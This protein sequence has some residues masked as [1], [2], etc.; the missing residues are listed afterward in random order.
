MSTGK[1]R[2]GDRQKDGGPETKKDR[3]YKRHRKKKMMQKQTNR[4][5]EQ[6]QRQTEGMWNRGIDKEKGRDRA[7]DRQ[8]RQRARDT[9]ASV[10]VVL[11]ACLKLGCFL[12][13]AN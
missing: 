9:L 10:H 7:R 6:R 4:T 2:D 11:A 8:L 5:T 3:K 12:S 1:L 13:Y